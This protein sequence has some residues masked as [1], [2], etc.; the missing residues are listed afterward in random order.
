MRHES[1]R[2]LKSGGWHWVGSHTADCRARGCAPHDSAD[3]ARACQ[4][5]YEIANATVV[6][7]TPAYAC[8]ECAANGA[9][10]VWTDKAMCLGGY[11]GRIVHLCDEHLTIEVLRKHVQPPTERWVS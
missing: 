8:A 11:M 2:E 10:K 4:H 5:E 9:P 7:L 1:A 6:T 3:A